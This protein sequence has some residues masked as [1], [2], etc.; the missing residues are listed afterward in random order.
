[1]KKF[2]NGKYDVV[3]KATFCDENDMG[4]IKTFLEKLLSIHIEEIKFL[5]PELILNDAEERKK[6]VDVLVKTE[7]EYIHIELNQIHS[8]YLHVRNFCYFMNIYSKHTRRGEEYDLVNQY[9]HIDFTYGIKDTEG[10]REYYVM[11]E[12]GKK[13]VENIRIIEYNMDKIMDYWYNNDEE[14]IA[15]YR[16]LMMLGVDRKSL[17][18][19]CKGDSFMEDYK[20]KIDRLNDSE[21]YTSWITPEEDARLMLNT[22][23]R[24][25]Y[26][27][28]MDEGLKQGMNEGLKQGKKESQKEMSIALLKEEIPIEIISKCTTLSVAEIE[29]L[30]ES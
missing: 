6:T 23:K 26:N 5:N 4:L 16:Y 14:K 3:F 27:E 7:Q 25:S 18:K 30:K 12:Q 20:K 13:Y 1:M 10:K 17:D 24:I 11:D 21:P 2:Y 28:G 9:I 29:Q 22:E 15:K 8:E 19:L